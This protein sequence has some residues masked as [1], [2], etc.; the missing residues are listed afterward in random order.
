MKRLGKCTVHVRSYVDGN[1]TKVK[2]ETRTVYERRG[3]FYCNWLSG[4]RE[5]TRRPDGAFDWEFHIRSLP[6]HTI[7]SILN[8]IKGGH[9]AK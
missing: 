1:L 7:D 8:R 9:I 2:T 5:V 4:D 3:K 6:V